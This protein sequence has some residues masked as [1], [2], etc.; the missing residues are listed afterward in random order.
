[1]K[2]P[3]IYVLLSYLLALVCALSFAVAD[4]PAGLLFMALAALGALSVTFLLP[5][6]TRR[7]RE[8]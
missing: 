4:E 5:R 1:M 8:Q 7:P 2:N 3:A 6:A